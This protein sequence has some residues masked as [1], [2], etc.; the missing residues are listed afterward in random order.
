M[1]LQTKVLEVTSPNWFSKRWCRVQ[2]LGKRNTLTKIE[3]AGSVLLIHQQVKTSLCQRSK[4]THLL[5]Q[6]LLQLFFHL[7]LSVL[8][9]A[10][11]FTQNVNSTNGLLLQLPLLL[12][13]YFALMSLMLWERES[14]SV[15]D[16][17]FSLSKN[18]AIFKFKLGTNLTGTIWGKCF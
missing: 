17:P 4:S 15:T 18:L 7:L 14:C 8:S 12:L 9:P 6:T 10:S 5:L 3:Q 1:N 11:H 13:D 16:T 2:W